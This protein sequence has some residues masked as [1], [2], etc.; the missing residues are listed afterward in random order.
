MGE[1]GVHRRIEM[2][3]WGVTDP[4]LIDKPEQNS[5]NLS[6]DQKLAYETYSGNW[7]RDWSQVIGPTAWKILQDV[8][9]EPFTPGGSRDKIGGKG[10]EA[11]VVH[12]LRAFAILELGEDIGT[13][14]ITSD[15]L[16]AYQSEEHMDNPAGMQGGVDVIIRNTQ[17]V[18]DID[19]SKDD[20]QLLSKLKGSCFSDKKQIQ[21]P[22]LYETNARG[23]QLHILN[24]KELVKQTLTDAANA[25]DPTIRRVKLGKALHAIED[26]YAHSN[27]IEV[28]LDQVLEDKD[29]KLKLDI[30]PKDAS[31]RNH[32]PASVDTLYAKPPGS[33][34]KKSQ[35]GP[36]DPVPLSGQLARKAI[37][38]GSFVDGDMIV[39]LAH[40][41]IPLTEALSKHIDK[42][43]DEW[44][45]V[46][47]KD[48]TPAFDKLKQD[49]LHKRPQLAI[50]E[51]WEGFDEA[52]MLFPIISLEPIKLIDTL[53]KA[54]DSSSLSSSKKALLK[55]GVSELPDIQI[56][57]PLPKK[58]R[59]K[60]AFEEYKKII[61]FVDKFKK[62]IEDLLKREIIKAIIDALGAELKDQLEFILKAIETFKAAVKRF[63]HVLLIRLVA[64]LLGIDIVKVA[65]SKHKT[66][67]ELADNLQEFEKLI[68]ESVEVRKLSL[69]SQTKI[70][71]LKT[72]KHNENIV[73][74][75]KDGEEPQLFPPSHS[76]VCKDHPPAHRSLFFEL[77]RD[78]AIQADRHIAALIQKIWGTP[79]IVT[80]SIQAPITDIGTLNDQA[81]K[82]AVS[83]KQV[84]DSSSF[85][86]T[87]KFAQN[88]S[89]GDDKTKLLNAVDLYIAHP[90][91]RKWWRPIFK[92]LL[93]DTGTQG[94]TD[95]DI[96]GGQGRN[97]TRASRIVA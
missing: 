61:E 22:L 33:I 27:F 45:T 52:G 23:L 60:E 72:V 16:G 32:N 95:G 49:S 90:A 43:I 40:V 68:L 29:D 81:Q 5:T 13:K 39:S 10:T 64:A 1:A 58:V 96:F 46:I 76:E 6:E 25:S 78:L 77:H 67:E 80:K 37:T 8:P 38:T 51:I 15:N 87:A 53:N 94:K 89:A 7:M 74:K 57:L 34:P 79:T 41:A 48:N 69:E 83:E 73:P 14:I 93:A 66:L 62:A 56:T 75:H 11:I 65:A 26:Y 28:A 9:K 84:M 36:D 24:T 19:A 50:A 35:G 21:E 86:T 97:Q 70:G 20:A 92:N 88:P 54:I 18:Y 71:D 44:L 12:A 42:T 47:P 85:G 17:G 55:K 63:I 59:A 31:L 4:G 2:D 3:A 91:D 82:A 30:L